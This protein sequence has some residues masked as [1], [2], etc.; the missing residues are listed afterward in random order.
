MPYHLFI[1][2]LFLASCGHKN[3]GS[4][5]DSTGEQNNNKPENKAILA[6][7]IL[8]LNDFHLAG[9]SD[10]QIKKNRFQALTGLPITTQQIANHLST[11]FDPNKGKA[12]AAMNKNEDKII[13]AAKDFGIY[14]TFILD[15]ENYFSIKNANFHQDGLKDIEADIVNFSETSDGKYISISLNLYPK[16]QNEKNIV[17]LYFSR[18]DIQEKSEQ[19]VDKN[20]Y[21]YQLLHE[22]G[23]YRMDPNQAIFFEFCSYQG[24]QKDEE[25]KIDRAIN[26]A[27]KD[28]QKVLGQKVKLSYKGINRFCESP[29]NV[30]SAE[31]IYIL[32]SVSSRGPGVTPSI[33]AADIKSK[34]F[35]K[36]A[37]FIFLFPQWGSG[38]NNS[39][40]GLNRLNVIR[41]EIGHLLGLAHKEDQPSTMS[42][43]SPAK[44]VTTYDRKAINGLYP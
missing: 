3:T 26:E 41:H 6:K 37:G 32:P 38:W 20:T 22:N 2:M 25:E 11:R 21:S 27:V 31:Q 28:W 14:L 23:A 15:S 4:I 18:K 13:L 12:I 35:I 43:F 8:K 24:L 44:N 5:N 33:Y 36:N 30:V 42:H 10:W 9:I 17:N 39:G 7:Q 34:T 19:L 29:G 1:L 16:N 40:D